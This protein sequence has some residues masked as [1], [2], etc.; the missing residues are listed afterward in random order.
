MAPYFSNKRMNPK[1]PSGS[2]FYDSMN[3]AADFFFF[4]SSKLVWGNINLSRDKCQSETFIQS[5]LFR[6]KSIA[7]KI[8]A[9]YILSG[10]SKCSLS[11]NH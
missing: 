10:F 3:V 4:F 1:D 5:I 2:K 9:L 7:L 11:V 8:Q 6:S